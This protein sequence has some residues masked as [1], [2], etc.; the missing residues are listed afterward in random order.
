MHSYGKELLALEINCCQI[1]GQILQSNFV[2][3][4]SSNP[5]ESI[6]TM[7]SLISLLTRG[8]NVVCD[9]SISPNPF[10][11]MIAVTA[12]MNQTISCF[13]DVLDQEVTTK[14]QLY[15]VLNTII[16]KSSSLP[17]EIYAL[18][19]CALDYLNPHSIANSLVHK[20]NELTLQVELSLTTFS[21]SQNVD[22]ALIGSL[23]RICGAMDSLSRNH[24]VSKSNRRQCLISYFAQLQ[25]VL[26]KLMSTL[27]RLIIQCLSPGHDNDIHRNSVSSTSGNSNGII[28]TNLSVGS[29]FNCVRIVV[30][31]VCGLLQCLGKKTF[32]KLAGDIFEI[33]VNF[34]ENLQQIIHNSSSERNSLSNHNPDQLQSSVNVNQLLFEGSG[35]QLTK[36]FLTLCCVLA[37]ST[38]ASSGSAS[39]QAISTHRLLVFVANRLNDETICAELLQST[40]K[41]GIV[42]ISCYWQKSQRMS[43]RI[44]PSHAG[45][46]N[47]FNMAQMSTLDS[48]AVNGMN[49]QPIALLLTQLCVGSLGPNVPPQD[50]LTAL[51]GLIS[52]SEQHQI[53]SA[54]WFQSQS[55]GSLLTPCLRAII[56]KIHSL[57]KDAIETVLIALAN[58]GVTSYI[59]MNSNTMSINTNEMNEKFRDFWYNIGRE[60]VSIASEY[61]CGDSANQIVFNVINAYISP[62]SDHLH[63]PANPLQ[64]SKH[65]HT[66]NS[67]VTAMNAQAVLDMRIFIDKVLS[68][69][70]SEI[71]RIL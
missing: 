12:L 69:I 61:N 3:Y 20:C 53:F 18:V 32:G 58:A 31:L 65:I 71:A 19:V 51:E 60:V 55:W 56:L 63:S 26:D 11:V 44:S 4:L 42:A 8:I 64:N 67:L 5:A 48:N 43:L 24:S 30:S 66:D 13:S 37:E 16:E 28:L 70:S 27:F 50:T 23:M 59:G 52:L 17:I 57:H 33:C 25:N 21:N 49:V 68:P 54:P 29:L 14:T 46:S 36:Q 22:K 15:E 10:A 62:N 47:S 7:Q 41:A 40:L 39:T 2:S 45:G 34:S 6:T 1:S 38:P 9:V 35:L